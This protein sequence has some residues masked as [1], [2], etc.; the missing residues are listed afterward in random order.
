MTHTRKL[1]LLAF[2]FIATQAAPLASAQKPDAW[3]T[4]CNREVSPDGKPEAGHYIFQ[5]R[6]KT[7][8]S[9]GRATFDYAATSSGTAVAYLTDLKGLMNPYSGPTLNLGYFV[10]AAGKE[11]P[12]IGQIGL[13]MIAKDF[14]AIPG[15][16]IALKLLVDGAVF[17][18]YTPK[19]SSGMYSLWFD[20]A[21]TDGDNKPPVLQPTQF[22]KLAKAIDAMKSIEIF[23]VQDDKDV[24]RIPIATP[25]MRVWRDALPEWAWN[26]A[27]SISET[28]TFCSGGDRVVN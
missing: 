8:G 26:T 9:G 11:P 14:K 23:L 19:E 18:P 25:T 3:L 4:R 2:A 6:G 13:N 7:P 27:K 16:P 15:N 22:A 12:S 5:T 10:S 1:A 17:G 20:T 24:V 21:D 28:T